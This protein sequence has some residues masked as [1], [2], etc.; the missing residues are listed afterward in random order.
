MPLPCMYRINKIAEIK[1]SPKFFINIT[2][3]LEG[4]LR[5]SE[6]NI[7][8]IVALN[9][10]SIFGALC[11][12]R[13]VGS[14]EHIFPYLVSSFF[15]F[16]SSSKEDC[17]F[18]PIP[19]QKVKLLYRRDSLVYFSFFAGTAHCNIGSNIMVHIEYKKIT[20]FL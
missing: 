17:D 4:G 7:S 13:Y 10:F 1:I 11:M 19:R 15:L 20:Y 14:K 5:W 9:F 18:Y 16:F 2:K 12:T 3:P 8:K 6:E